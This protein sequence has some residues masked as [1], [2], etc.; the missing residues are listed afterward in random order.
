MFSDQNKIVFILS[1]SRRQPSSCYLLHNVIVCAILA[2]MC[3]VFSLHG[4]MNDPLDGLPH[5]QQQAV[6][7]V[8]EQ[9]ARPSQPR[10][11]RTR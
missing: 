10:L 8:K 5:Y 11:A 3:F 9:V 1:L 4:N 2:A 6:M 7:N